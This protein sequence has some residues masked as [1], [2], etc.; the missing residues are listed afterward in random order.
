MDASPSSDAL[1]L[2]GAL[3]DLCRVGDGARVLDFGC[4]RGGMVKDLTSL[5]F[6]MWGCDNGL[7][8]QGD[9]RPNA[10]LLEIGVAPYRLPFDDDSFDA[11]ISCSVMEHARNKEEAFHEIRRILKPGGVMMHF[12]PSKYY[13]PTEPHIFVPFASWLWPNV[14]KWWLSLWALAGVKNDFQ[15]TMNWQQRAADNVRYCRDGLCYWPLRRYRKAVTA[16]FGNCAIPDEYYIR[17]AEGGAARLARKIPL[18]AKVTG[19]MVART[20]MALLIARK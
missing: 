4:G 15:Q 9:Y 16:I 5:G 11:V 8:R 6:D 20:R 10:R 7:F 19:W 18:P 13:L 1:F 17:K 2:A 12:F 14:P 3:R